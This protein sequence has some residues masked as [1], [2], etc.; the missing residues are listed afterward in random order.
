M[1]VPENVILDS[2]E[3]S[4]NRT[5]PAKGSAQTNLDE[6]VDEYVLPLACNRISSEYV[7]QPDSGGHAYILS[8]STYQNV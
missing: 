7:L 8:E 4:A 2:S 5:N 6:E 1:L 3:M